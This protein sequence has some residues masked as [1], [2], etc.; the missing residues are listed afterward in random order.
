MTGCKT[1]QPVVQHHTVTVTEVLRD[2]SVV[3]QPDTASIK[4]RFECDSL[5]QVI[6]KELSIEKGR[7]VTPVVTYRDKFLQVTMPVDSEAVYFSWKERYTTESD[8]MVVTKIVTVN[9]KPPWYQKA[10]SWVGAISLVVLL[11]MF[12]FKPLWFLKN[13][14]KL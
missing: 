10:L 1:P 4:A 7:K 3:I 2:T 8:S 9:D 6:M 13:S 11:L 14:K 5:N 12:K